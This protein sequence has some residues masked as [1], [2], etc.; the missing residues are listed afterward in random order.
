MKK[1][2]EKLAAVADE[3]DKL[4]MKKI[5]DQLDTIL[6][7]FAQGAV[8]AE[9]FYQKDPQTGQFRGILEYV[10]ETGTIHFV[11]EQPRVSKDLNQLKGELEALVPNVQVEHKGVSEPWHAESNMPFDRAGNRVG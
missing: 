1:I 6:E 2:F 11:P 9:A 4:G 10:D 5:A 7:S 8:R 3:C